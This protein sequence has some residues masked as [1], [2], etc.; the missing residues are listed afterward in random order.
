[1]PPPYVAKVARFT[2]TR[3]PQL[4]PSQLNERIPEILN[5]QKAPDPIRYGDTPARQARVQ[6]Y[7]VLA[8]RQ[9]RA[10]MHDGQSGVIGKTE[11]ELL[12]GQPHGKS[13]TWDERSNIVHQIPTPYGSGFQTIPQI[14][15]N[16]RLRRLMKL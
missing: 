15:E 13:L 14:P 10:V 2:A 3:T 12:V 11:F 9:I 6:R 5:P 16:E 8:K 4:A 1:M 7:G